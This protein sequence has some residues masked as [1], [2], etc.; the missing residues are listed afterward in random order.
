MQVLALF[1]KQSGFIGLFGGVVGLI[2]AYLISYILEHYPFIQIP[3]VYLLASLPVEYNWKVYA[4][5][6]LGSV[7][8]S[9]LAGIYP[10][11]AATRIQPVK[12]L[13]EANEI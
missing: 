11:W 9:C 10:A 8:L 1:V 12:G 5:V 7:F 13:N 3:D 6:F 2:L 4:Y